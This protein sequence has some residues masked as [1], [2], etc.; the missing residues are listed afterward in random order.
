MM[1]L[2]V[3]LLD[4]EIGFLDFFNVAID[5]LGKRWV[6][7]VIQPAW[8]LELGFAFDDPGIGSLFAVKSLR[9][10]VDDCAA[11]LD[12]DLGDEGFRAVF[13]STSYYGAHRVVP[14]L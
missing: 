13:P 4:L 6:L 7:F 3:C 9:L 2:S 12:D 10:A 11:F 5:H 1:A 8:A 14:I